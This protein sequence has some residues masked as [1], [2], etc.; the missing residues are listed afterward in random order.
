MA[1]NGSAMPS[2]IKIALFKFF[3]ILFPTIKLISTY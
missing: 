2:E 1:L 3:M